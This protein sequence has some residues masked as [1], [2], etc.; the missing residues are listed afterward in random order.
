VPQAPIAD[1]YPAVIDGA[2]FDRVQVLIKSRTSTVRSAHIASIVAGLARCPKCG[3]TMTR[4][5]KGS[6]SRAGIPKLVCAKAKAGAGCDYHGVRLPAVEKALL[7]AASTLGN[8]PAPDEDLTDSIKGVSGAISEVEATI[9]ALADQIERKSSVTLSKRLAARESQVEKMRK[10]LQAL[11]QRA[12]DSSSAV[13]KHRAARLRDCLRR[14]K[15]RPG[16]IA[17][18]NSALRECVES[19]TVDYPTGQL[20]LKWRHGVTSTLLYSWPE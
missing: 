17:A 11:E 7:D 18:A 16:E 12:A 4:V 19:V 8:P 2:M 20:I 15:Q 13:V 14:L 5:M 9:E 1:Y 10:D 6:S 3:A